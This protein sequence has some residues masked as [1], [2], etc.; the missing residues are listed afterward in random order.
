MSTNDMHHMQA[1]C[2]IPE[3]THLAI[4]VAIHN[5]PND[6]VCVAKTPYQNLVD[7]PVIVN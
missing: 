7:T 4:P 3:L 5:Y 2:I 6:P 1:G